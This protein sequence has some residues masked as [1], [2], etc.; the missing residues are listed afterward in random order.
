MQLN[1]Y[2]NKVEDYLLQTDEPVFELAKFYCTLYGIKG[3]KELYPAIGKLTKQFGISKVYEAIV[4]NYY[5]ASTHTKKKFYT[6]LLFSIKNAE[7]RLK[8]ANA[9]PTPITYTEYS[10]LREEVNVQ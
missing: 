3:F 10:K 8:I 1:E 5:K 2:I 6:N 7:K 4:E 9:E